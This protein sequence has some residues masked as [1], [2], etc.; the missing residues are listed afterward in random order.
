M[1]HKLELYTPKLRYGVNVTV[2]RG[3]D[4]YE[5]AK[6]GDEIEIYRTDDEAPIAKGL[7][8]AIDVK[9]FRKVTIQELFDEHDD[10][11]HMPHGLA[12]SLLRTYPGF[13]L[14][15]IVT[16]IQFEIKYK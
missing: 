12:C 13:T 2:R 3:I 15:D 14:D 10:E 5:R 11:C 9:P 4:W 8:K 1:K 16:V 7:I 6:V